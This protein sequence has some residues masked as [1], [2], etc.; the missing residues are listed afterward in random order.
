MK[1]L[2]EVMSGP[3]APRSFVIEPGMEVE[4]G[5]EAP[6][7]IVLPDDHSVSRRH[8]A[9]RFDGENCRIR[10]LGSA[11]GTTVNGRPV[12]SSGVVDNDL[13]GA[14]AT[15]LRVT[16]AENF[17]SDVRANAPLA[18]L[19]NEPAATV[20]AALETQKREVVATTSH[21]RVLEVLGNQKEPVFAILDAA[22]NP[23]ILAWLLD[24]E[25][26]YQS[27]YEGPEA[28]KMMAVAPYLVAVPPYSGF[29]PRLVRAGW[30]QSWGVYLTCDRPFDEVRKHLRRF[31]TVETEDGKK[32][33]F[34]FYDP[35][36]LSVFLPSCTGEESRTFFG[37]VGNYLLESD[38]GR[39]LVR[40]TDDALRPRQDVIPLLGAL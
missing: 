3:N 1:V 26:K 9:L 12:A 38:G 27:L 15:V 31:L 18:A 21:D 19:P 11:H 37:P 39:A 7:Q 25:E 20:P 16:I 8:F 28:D 6:A 10:D 35:R 34:R 5:R 22:R 13:I 40:F 23:L 4:V 2:L 24:C 36:V 29:L 33:V 17:N 32:L 14:G 30:G